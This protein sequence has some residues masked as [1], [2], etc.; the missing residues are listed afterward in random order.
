MTP[1]H[2]Q[3]AVPSDLVVVTINSSTGLSLRTSAPGL[4]N[5]MVI[6]TTQPSSGRS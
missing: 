6:G 3:V 1:V 5:L 4:R 2:W